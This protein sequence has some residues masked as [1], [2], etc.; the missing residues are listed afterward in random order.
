MRIEAQTSTKPAAGVIATRP[1]TAPAAAPSTLG[2]PLCSHD[3][4]IQVSAAIAAAVFVTTNALA[5]RPPAVIAL[6]AL[7]PNQPNQSRDAPWTVM[8]AS[9]GSS[10]SRPY[11]TPR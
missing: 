6:P 2:A 11:P 9:C 5:A 7:K 8:V 3:T 1:A 10:A 4:V